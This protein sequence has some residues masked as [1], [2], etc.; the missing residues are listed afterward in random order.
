MNGLFWFR[1]DLRLHDNAALLK[2]AAQA[3]HLLCVYV[4][5]PARGAIRWQ[6]IHEALHDLHQQLA[7]LGQTLTIRVGQPETVIAELIATHDIQIIGVTHVPATYERRAVAQLQK[8]HR[9]QQWVVGDSF[10]L[11]SEAQLPFAVRD[12]P[13]RNCSLP[14]AICRAVS[15]RSA[16]V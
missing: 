11:F 3:Q 7:A 6:F 8:T 15:P 4:V 13:W 10:T 16:N 1:H 2:V 14:C 5:D 9:R 12:L